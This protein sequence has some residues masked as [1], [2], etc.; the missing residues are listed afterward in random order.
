M[1]RR[2]KVI[3]LFPCLL[4][5]SFVVRKLTTWSNNCFDFFL[6]AELMEEERKRITFVNEMEDK[7]ALR[8]KNILTSSISVVVRVFLF[9]PN[10]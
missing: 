5:D 3:C 10:E 6:V 9:H 7:N 2:I 4:D 8:D 1:L